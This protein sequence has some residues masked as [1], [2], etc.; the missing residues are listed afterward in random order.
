MTSFRTVTIGELFHQGAIVAIQDGNHGG[1]HPKA[2]DYVESGVPFVMAGDIRDGRLL[3][4]TCKR[5]PKAR[6]DLLRIGFARSGDVLL[7]HKGTVGEVAIVPSVD[8]YVML[9]PQ[10]TYYRTDGSKLFNRYPPVST[11]LSPG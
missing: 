10:V 2:S 11:Y 7:T 9:T 4:D 8:D 5:L 6:T 1:D 3:L